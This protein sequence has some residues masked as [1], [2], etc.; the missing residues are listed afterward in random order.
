[1]RTI[2][3]CRKSFLFYDGEAWKKKEMEKCFDVTMGSY[4]DAEICEL[5]GIFILHNLSQVVTKEDIGLYRND[6]LMVLRNST[7]RRAD[8]LRKDIM[9]VFKNIG[10][11][12]DI[13]ANMKA[14]DFLDVTFDLPSGT[15]RPYKK[16]NN[17]LQ[18][19]HISSN[20]PANI[21]KQLPIPINRRLKNN[22]SNEV[23][24][25][26]AKAE[27]EEALKHSGY[28]D[29]KLSFNDDNTRPNRRSRKR[30]V[31]R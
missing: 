17:Q 14:V 21:L 20:H 16:P 18:Y 19:I 7:K 27:Y 26:K 29:L 5:I 15:Y 25:N 2:F 11:D 6:R 1:M 4:D 8:I 12:I 30:S 9:K 13:V 10:F 22:S 28:K 23:V 31:I 3:Q 24:F